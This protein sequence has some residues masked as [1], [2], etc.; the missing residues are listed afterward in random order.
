MWRRISPSTMYDVQIELPWSCELARGSGALSQ[1]A[2]VAAIEVHVRLD[3]NATSPQPS[4]LVE[5]M[6]SAGDSNDAV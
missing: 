4:T 5:D 1:N 6:G 2:R 3:R